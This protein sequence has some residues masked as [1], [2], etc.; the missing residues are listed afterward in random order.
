MGDAV[1]PKDKINRLLAWLNR[2]I[3]YTGVEFGEA[4]IVPRTPDETQ[5]RGF[6]DCKDKATLL[7]A[8]LRASDIQAKVA[9]LSTG[10]G[11]DV[12]PELP[13]LNHFDHAIV[14]VPGP[15]PL[16]IDPTDEYARAGE[17]PFAD[18]G[19]LALIV[20]PEIESLTRTPEVKSLDNKILETREVFLADSGK[21]RIVETSHPSGLAEA[22]LRRSFAPSDPKKLKE[23]LKNYVQKEYSAA[24]LGETAIGDP[25][26]FRHPFTVKLEALQTNIGITS[27][28]DAA[29]TINAWSMGKG[30]R[31]LI[32]TSYDRDE[33]DPVKTRKQDLIFPEPYATEWRY[34]IVLPVGFE[35]KPLP[36]SDRLAFGPASLTRT[37]GRTPE[38]GI[39]ATFL[40]DS[41]KARWTA[42]EV[43]SARTAMEA[44]GKSAPTKLWFDQV[45]EAHLAAGRI[46]EAIQAFHSQATAQPGKGVPL[47]R[48]AIALIRGGLGDAAREQARKA[49]QLEPKNMFT[50][51]ALGW[52][53]L[54]DLANRPYQKGWDYA[55]AVAAY[56]KA[57]ELDPK[58]ALT[59]KNLALLLEHNV[60]GERYGPGARLDQAIKEYQELRKDLQVEDMNLNLLVVLWRSNRFQEVEALA[61]SLPT[62]NDVQGWRIA[63]R[64][65]L[66]GVQAALVEARGLSLD[67][68]SRRAAMLKAGDILV[69]SRYYPE[70]A[71][72]LSESADG[73]ANAPA[74]RSRV[75]VLAKTR[76]FEDVVMDPNNPTTVVW[77]LMKMA[78][79][80]S[81]KS[82]DLLKYLTPNLIA[83]VDNDEGLKRLRKTLGYAP[84]N[85]DGTGVS[86]AVGLDV[87]VALSQVVVEGNE[88]AGFRVRIQMPWNA[89]S[90]NDSW[91][92][93]REKGQLLLAAMDEATSSFGIEA[94]RRLDLG[95]VAGARLMLDRAREVV[96]SGGGDEPLSG[97]PFCRFWVKGQEA[98][99]QEIRVAA[100][101][102]LTPEKDSREAV[103]I[104]LQGR[105]GAKDETARGRFDIALLE[106]YMARSEWAALE[107]VSERLVQANPLSKKAA[108]ARIMALAGSKKWADMLNF[109]NERLTR[110]PFDT[111]F[112]GSKASALGHLGRLEEQEQLLKAAIGSG[113]ANAMDFN[114][115]A[116]GDLVRGKVTEQSVDWARRSVLLKPEKNGAAQHTLASLLTERG[117][118][119]EAL[120]L[121]FK[122]VSSR[123]EEELRS[124]DWYLIGR[125]A[126]QFGEKEA[127][128]GNYQRV[129]PPK[130]TEAMEGSCYALA[131]KRLKVLGKS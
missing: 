116:W 82:K 110:E 35:A 46:K 32:P 70:A 61:A 49:C 20:S 93:V 114:N 9:L 104:L 7:V 74:I 68:T 73:D 42:A 57:K 115:L 131:A 79:D 101:S 65:A 51:R 43:E 98:T 124:E 56:Q 45:G 40:F 69:S 63:A 86:S 50:Q 10:P 78:T 4:S 75:A 44:F 8:L 99:A 94:F 71:A 97:H 13:G 80:G 105:L 1:E 85:K 19:R 125:I 34:K 113:K 109:T 23:N 103:Q 39:L 123:E 76:R 28:L 87:L 129:T 81:T 64:A 62:S 108:V 55:G 130:E 84:V 47:S 95:D 37:Y 96:W 15:R 117:E 102:L 89:E 118:T 59:R 11:K 16:W 100:A 119:N 54:H 120:E 17:L 67:Q 53:L 83:D 112:L 31:N 91:F 36:E 128:I 106:A 52:V 126:E 2:T 14:F 66:K 38:G 41:G 30:L 127:A 77:R 33:K 58:D 88:A 3:R 72:I 122:E 121:F 27:D 12:N 26:D 111:E 22:A 24:D 18:Q 60:E 25:S 90:K 6:G 107:P 5:K 21:A 48:L 92:V 29:L